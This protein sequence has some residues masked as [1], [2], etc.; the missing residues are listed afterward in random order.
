MNGMLSSH[1]EKHDMNDW[2]DIENKDIGNECDGYI[3]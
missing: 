1:L 3:I 2:P